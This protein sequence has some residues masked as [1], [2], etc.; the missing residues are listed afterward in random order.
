[1][2]QMANALLLHL[3]PIWSLGMSVADGALEGGSNRK[4]IPSAD[5]SFWFLKSENTEF[6]D[7]LRLTDRFLGLS[8]FDIERR[9][10]K[11]DFFKLPLGVT[12]Q[13]IEISEGKLRSVCLSLHSDVKVACAPSS[14]APCVLW[15]CMD[16]RAWEKATRLFLGG[17]LSLALA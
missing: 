3:P 11:E 14:D 12:E 9:D 6:N 5:V 13:L 4:V 1:M 16:V 17:K 10:Q 15:L 2:T 7:L 8:S